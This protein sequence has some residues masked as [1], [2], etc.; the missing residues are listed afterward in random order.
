LKTNRIRRRISRRY[1][2]Q[3]GF[4]KSRARAHTHTHTHTQDER[5]Y[6]SNGSENNTL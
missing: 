2:H 6:F 4:H 1:I 3:C 5:L